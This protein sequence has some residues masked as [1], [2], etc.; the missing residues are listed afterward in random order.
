VTSEDDTGALTGSGTSS[1]GSA[2][3]FTGTIAIQGA[4]NL[5]TDIPGGGSLTGHFANGTLTGTIDLTAKDST[6]EFT[7]SLPS[8]HRPGHRRLGA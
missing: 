8:A 1:N 2:F 6:G 7:V 4:V 5:T 3:D